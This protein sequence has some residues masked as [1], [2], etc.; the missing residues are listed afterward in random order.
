MP[1][2]EIKTR[3]NGQKQE[4]LENLW[5]E[6]EKA[7]LQSASV[8]VSLTNYQA[9]EQLTGS[10][11]D[12]IVLNIEKLTAMVDQNEESDSPSSE[13]E[14]S[15]EE[16]F[17]TMVKELRGHLIKSIQTNL[18]LIESS[19]KLSM[20]NERLKKDYAILDTKHKK[21][22]ENIEKILMNITRN[23]N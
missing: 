2:R 14:P 11:Q 22:L 9:L 3:H 12:N 18:N 17:R 7:L 23:P 1:P 19:T 20:E 4:A 13:L 5:I 15:S 10:L 21:A 16:I 6:I 8:R